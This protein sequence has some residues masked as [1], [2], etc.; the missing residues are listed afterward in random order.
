M[1]NGRL[2]CWRPQ[3]DSNPCYRRERAASTILGRPLASI[4]SLD[5]LIFL[6]IACTVIHSG[7][8]TSPGHFRD[9]PASKGG[10]SYGA[11][12]AI[13]KVGNEIGQ[14]EIAS[15]EEASIRQDRA[16]YQPRLSPQPDGRNLGGAYCRRQGW[17][18]DQSHRRGRRF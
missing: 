6:A 5:S 17:E 8:R 12:H 1:I 3:G 18:L 13:S 7:P 4:K 14:T 9:T 11:Q 16:G 2:K 15:R 10:N